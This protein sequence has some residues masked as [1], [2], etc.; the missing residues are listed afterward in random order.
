MDDGFVQ[1]ARTTDVPPGKMLKVA[2]QGTEILLVNT[3]GEYL[4]VDN[5]CTHEDAS[6][7]LGAL[8]G[9]YIRCPLHGSRFDLRTGIPL[10][11]P[12]EEPLRTF[13]VR[14]E[15]ESVLV[16]PARRVTQEK[17]NTGT[18]VTG[19]TTPV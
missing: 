3:E 18:W 19:K 12:A 4:A 1:V 13:P 8:H 10:E 7:A 17:I 6:L 16:G 14:V 5:C 15:G 11:E 2:A 9:G